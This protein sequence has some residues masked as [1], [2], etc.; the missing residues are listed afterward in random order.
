MQNNISAT[1]LYSWHSLSLC[2]EVKALPQNVRDVGS[3]PT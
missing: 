1:M 3:N 2:L